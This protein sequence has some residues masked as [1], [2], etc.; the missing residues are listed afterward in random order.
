MMLTVSESVSTLL[1][2]CP[3]AEDVF[4]LYGV[5]AYAIEGGLSLS[6]ACWLHQLDE[7][8]VL[9]DLYA[10]GQW[11][12]EPELPTPSLTPSDPPS[13]TDEPAPPEPDPEDDLPAPTLDPVWDEYIDYDLTL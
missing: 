8:R 4:A 1:R 3:W 9:R 7:R 5:D 2:R 12:D 11:T 6:G 13:A 10:A